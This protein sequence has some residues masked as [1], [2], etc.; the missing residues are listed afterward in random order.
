MSLFLSQ[1]VIILALFLTQPKSMFYIV[2]NMYLA[3][4]YNYGNS[5]IS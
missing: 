2:Y 5:C 1:F 4:D 3:D